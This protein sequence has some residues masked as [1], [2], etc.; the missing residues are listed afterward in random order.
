MNP[1]IEAFIAQ[2]DRWVAHPE[3]LDYDPPTLG[4][5]AAVKDFLMELGRQNKTPPTQVVSTGDGGI[6]AISSFC[7]AEF[8]P[9]ED[10]SVTATMYPQGVLKVFRSA[11]TIRIP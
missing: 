11:K 10:G 5:A 4:V 1:E 3:D 9:N 8:S 2:I 7:R 6:A